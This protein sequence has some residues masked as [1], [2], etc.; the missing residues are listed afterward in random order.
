MMLV[1]LLLLW[2]RR[3]L[4]LIDVYCRRHARRVVTPA[5]AVLPTVAVSVATRRW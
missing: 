5:S 3:L 4:L 2:L 1:L